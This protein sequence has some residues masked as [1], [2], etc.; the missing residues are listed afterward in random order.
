MARNQRDQ[1]CEGEITPDDQPLARTERL[2]RQQDWIDSWFKENEL[3]HPSPTEYSNE[4]LEKQE[5]LV[6]ILWLAGMVSL[7]GFYFLVG[8]LVCYLKR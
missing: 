8:P 2:L 7:A 1:H 4:R 6:F 3:A 5:R